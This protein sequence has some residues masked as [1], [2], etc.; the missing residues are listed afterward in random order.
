MKS[1]KTLN[2]FE[3]HQLAIA[4]K[5]LEM[6]DVF[7]KIMGGPTKEEAKENIKRLS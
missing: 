1:K 2:V 3:K 6:N 7:A 5:T 4:K